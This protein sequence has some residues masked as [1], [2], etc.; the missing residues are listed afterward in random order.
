VA[1]RIEYS[2]VTE[3]H[4]RAL[5]AG[6]QSLVLATAEKQLA[7]QPTAETRNRKPMRPN[8]LATWELRV[9]NLRVY[10]VVEEEP[11]Q[12]VSIRAI[13]VKVRDRVRIANEEIEL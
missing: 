8:L 12:V 4:L 7:R 1:Y 2:P 10:Y 5:T 3:A 13:G 9:R 11:E 6:Q